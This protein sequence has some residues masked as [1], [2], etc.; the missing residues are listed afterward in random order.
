MPSVSHGER[1]AP[2]CDTVLKYL[3]RYT[4][5][6]A[7]S[8]APPLKLQSAGGRRILSVGDGAV[9]FQY[10]DYA[11]HNRSKE[12]TLSA[13]EL[14]RRFLLHVVPRGFMRI[15]HYG[16]TANRHRE[17][18]LARARELLGQSSQLVAEEKSSL[19]SL[20]TNT[21]DTAPDP[22]TCPACGGTMRVVEIIAPARRGSFLL[23]PAPHD[24]S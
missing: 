6:V 14:L 3:S 4:H 21:T 5:R 11:D 2:P 23:L 18:K 17:Q 12:M 16:V 7:I 10:R 22:S 15:R 8:N 9:R 19:D 1:L 20:E 13:T 24:T